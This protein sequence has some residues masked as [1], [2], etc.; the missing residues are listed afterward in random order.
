MNTYII[1]AGQQHDAILIYDSQETSNPYLLFIMLNAN[2]GVKVVLDNPACC[3][4]PEWQH[5]C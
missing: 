4:N 1:A 5:A 3:K 2:A